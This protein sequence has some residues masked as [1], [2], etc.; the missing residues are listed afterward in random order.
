MKK[1]AMFG[2]SRFFGDYVDL[3]HALG[4]VLS[5]VVVNVPDPARPGTKTFADRF[6]DYQAWL[7]A[8]GSPHRAGVVELSRYRPDPEETC[9]VGFRGLSSQPLRESLKADFGL[10]FPPLIHPDASVSPF[11]K[12]G[13]GAVVCAGAVVASWVDIGPFCLINRN[14]SVGHDTVIGADTDVSPNAAI[15]SA[16][17]IEEAVRVGI[18]ATV[19]EELRLREGCYVAAGAAVIA[20]V[21]PWMVV[22]GVPAAVK[23][24]RKR[25]P[26]S[27]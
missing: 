15:A 27:D 4:G 10:V 3:I 7:Q 26:R 2:Q 13:E 21:P 25:P 8:R 14:A 11:A 20:D 9:L 12:V 19:I 6:E 16:V 18:G 5:R 23:K 22:A 17:V 1:F 24:E